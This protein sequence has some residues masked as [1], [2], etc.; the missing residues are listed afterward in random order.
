MEENHV[1]VREFQIKTQRTFWYKRE[2]QDF[3]S[4]YAG[5]KRRHIMNT[6]YNL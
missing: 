6:L 1:K 3:F 5:F 4:A 2:G